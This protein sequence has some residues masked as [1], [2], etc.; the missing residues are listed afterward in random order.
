MS[1]E[2]GQEVPQNIS[3]H[4]YNVKQLLRRWAHFQWWYTAIHSNLNSSFSATYPAG[5][6]LQ[7]D[8]GDKAVN[9]DTRVT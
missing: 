7:S 8:H 4:S 5:A 6:F 1:K 3:N 2:Q 9:F